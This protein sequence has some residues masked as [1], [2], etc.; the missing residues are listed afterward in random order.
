MTPA[1]QPWLIVGQGLA[2]SC[3][4]WEFW[5]RGVPFQILDR[6]NGGCSRIAAGLINPITGKNFEPSWRINDFHSHAI[7][8][9]ENL[10]KILGTRLWHPLPVLRLATSAKEWEKISSKLHLSEISHWIEPADT[11]APP[12]FHGAVQLSGGGRIDTANFINTT[13]NFFSDRSLYVTSTYAPDVP[14]K[15][16]ILCQGAE[17]LMLNQL[18]PH[19]C[20]KGEILTLRA[21]WPESHIRIGA[22]GWLVPIGNRHFRVGSTYEWNQLDELP[23]SA[24]SERILAIVAKLGGPDFEIIDHVA[25]IRPILRRSQPLIG[26]N[27]DDTWVFNALGSKGALYAPKMAF[28]LAEWIINGRRPDESLIISC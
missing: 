28:Y 8:F 10:E 7:A 4:A 12:G 20:A 13:R 17:G 22:G 24:G 1:E 6:G 5:Q 14:G 16:R 27:M 18:G 19:R 3:L 11:P 21:P 26:K 9:Y 23:T 25:A 2:G 15:N